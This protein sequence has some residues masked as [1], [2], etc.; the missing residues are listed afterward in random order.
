MMTM[1][2]NQ[3]TRG[4]AKLAPKVLEEVVSERFQ[5][6]TEDDTGYEAMQNVLNLIK[7]GQL[8]CVH[9]FIRRYN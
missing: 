3:N 4:D 6:M 2:W 5:A 9:Q 1:L 8:E 7:N